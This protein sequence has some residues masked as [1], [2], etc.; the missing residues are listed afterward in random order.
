MI[1]LTKFAHR[2]FRQDFAGTKIPVTPEEFLRELDPEIE[3]EGPAPFIRY[4]WV[5][6]EFGV[7]SGVHPVTP[8]NEGLLR[9]GYEKRREGELPILT[10]W[11]PA[12]SVAPAECEWLQLVCYSADQ[13]DKEGEPIPGEYLWGIV[14]IN[15]AAEPS[16]SPM[17]PATLL[18]NALG[19]AEGGNGE[20]LDR[21]EYLRAVEYWSQWAVI[22]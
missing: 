9:T 14:A 12:G 8:E 10:R 13:L 1:T 7:L 2:Q 5:R 18:R 22:K 3:G 11:F 17:L 4:F 15:S 19:T 16:N 6:N 21:T 20:S